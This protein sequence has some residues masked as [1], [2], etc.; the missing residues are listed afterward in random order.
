MNTTTKNIERLELAMKSGNC[1]IVEGALSS[2]KT[3]LIHYLSE[4]YNVKLIKYQIDD[5]MDDK[6]N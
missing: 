3:S 6:V 5:N 2:G 1:I 4:K